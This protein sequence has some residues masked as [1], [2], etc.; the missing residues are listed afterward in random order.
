M[1]GEIIAYKDGTHVRL[2]G[3]R[4]VDNRSRFPGVAAAMAALSAK[5][6]DSRR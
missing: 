2:I 1:A 3:R 5:R 6:A 4:G